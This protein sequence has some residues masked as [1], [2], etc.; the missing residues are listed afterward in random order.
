MIDGKFVKKE[1]RVEFTDAYHELFTIDERISHF[2]GDI[3]SEGE[4]GKR[5]AAAQM[6]MSSL[7]VKRHKVQLVEDEAADEA[8][9]II[10]QVGASLINLVK[11]LGGIRSK[12]PGGKYETLANTT[13]MAQKIVDYTKRIDTALE[14]MTRTLELMDKIKRME[15]GR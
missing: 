5:Y 9:Q 14:T 6:D 4:L 10:D 8:A 13:D 15:A 12:S 3:S 2:E 1:N 7:S 11:I